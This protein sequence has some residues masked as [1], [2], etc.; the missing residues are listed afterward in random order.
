MRVNPEQVLIEDGIPS[1]GRIKK[2]DIKQAFSNSH[3]Q[4]DSNNRCGQQL[5]PCS[6]IEGPREQWHFHPGHS[7]G[8]HTVNRN[9]EIQSR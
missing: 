2:S 6:S 1:E 9:N 7:R 5:N 4:G 8:S 3:Q